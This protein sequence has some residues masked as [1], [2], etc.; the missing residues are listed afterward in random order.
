MTHIQK[1]VKNN[2]AYK[3]DMLRSITATFITF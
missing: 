2:F 3:I 1:K